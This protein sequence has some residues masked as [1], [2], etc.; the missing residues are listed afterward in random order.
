MSHQLDTKKEIILGTVYDLVSKFMY[1]DRKEC[2]ELP[3]GAIQDAVKA[4]EVSV[5]EIVEC[6][7][8]ELETSL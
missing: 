5:D 8:A 7:R 3:V 1:Y 6:F 4:G 2:E